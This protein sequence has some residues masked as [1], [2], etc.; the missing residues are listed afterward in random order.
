MP[1][2]ESTYSIAE[3]TQAAKA[4]QAAPECVRAALKAKKAQR[5][6]F[7]EAKSIVDAFMKQEVK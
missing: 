7:I 4:L 1:E 5:F 6:T 3:L 2:P